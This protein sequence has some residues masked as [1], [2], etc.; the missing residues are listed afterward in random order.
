M[1]QLDHQ[2]ENNT[3]DEYTGF[4][5]QQ[6]S[7]LLSKTE[8][9][10]QEERLA[11]FK[12]L[13]DRLKESQ[14]LSISKFIYGDGMVHGIQVAN[15]CLM[16]NPTMSEIGL[17]AA[18][19][20]D[21]DRACGS[22]RKHQADYPKTDDGYRQFKKEHALNSAQ[23]FCEAL[24]GIYEPEII[25]QVKTLI[26]QHEEGGEGDLATIDFADAMVLFSPKNANNYRTEKVYK[27]VTDPDELETLREQGFRR[28]I[29]F[30]I[31]SLSPEDRALVIKYTKSVQSEYKAPTLEVLQ[32]EL[33]PYIDE[34]TAPQAKDIIEGIRDNV[35]LELHTKA[36]LKQTPTVVKVYETSE[37]GEE[38]IFSREEATKLIVS[39]AMTNSLDVTKL[40]VSKIINDKKG[41]LL[42]LEIE[43]PNPEGGGHK[44]INY[45]I[46]GK[47]EKMQSQTTSLDRT[48]WDADDMPEAPYGGVVAEYL[49][50][51]W[52]FED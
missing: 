9:V 15:F 40:K 3:L 35:A 4:Q 25:Q 19:G 26:E 46:K 5:E 6:I 52:R 10:L 38:R 31:E 24:E 34:L 49:E 28:K 27:G 42:V 14:D 2:D 50:G 51:K 45:T 43:S 29:H 18:I 11:K 12:E 44:L 20:H 33:Q 1:R 48:F 16:K 7:E 41:N 36:L 21:W 17:L 13:I 47:H 37:I 30:M 22:K 39:F 8:G 32:T 23:L